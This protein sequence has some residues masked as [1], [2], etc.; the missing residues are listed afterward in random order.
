[1]E[2]ERGVTKRHGVAVRMD[3]LLAV[4]PCCIFGGTGE[5]VRGRGWELVRV[6]VCHGERGR[7]A[8]HRVIC[9]YVC[10]CVKIEYNVM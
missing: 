1:M 2:A 4:A 6:C 8:R 5:R 10:V 9:V 7:L 3:Q